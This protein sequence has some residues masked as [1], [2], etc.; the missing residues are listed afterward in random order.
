M[1]RKS[2][3]VVVLS[4]LLLVLLAGCCLSHEWEE[5]T[6]TA[7]QTCAKCG[8]TEG[9]PL[10]HTWEDAT[11]TAPKTCSVCG[12]T[13]GD[14]LPH[15]WEE[16]TCSAPK[17][18]SVCGETEGDALPH[19][20]EDATCTKAKTCSVCGKTSGA[21]LGH[22]TGDWEVESEPTEEAD[23]KYVKICSVCGKVVES[24]V[25]RM[26]PEAVTV[27]TTG[28]LVMSE[29]EY[30]R[31]FLRYLS[32]EY[33]IDSSGDLIKRSGSNDFEIASIIWGEKDESYKDTITFMGP[34]AEIKSVL[35][36]AINSIDPNA[37][38]AAALE[39]WEAARNLRTGELTGIPLHT[40]MIIAYK[41]ASGDYQ[42]MF[43]TLQYYLE[44]VGY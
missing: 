5:A 8:K 17:T 18:C 7:P 3:V 31:H 1:K 16:A 25:Y 9:E 29:E 4:L 41:G 28:G 35:D 6:C 33:R 10:P 23:G 37:D 32:D 12:E 34:W 2:I 42:A 15:E 21:P 13:K 24:K 38:A 22:E 36:P 43:C 11:C 14:T 30:H 44:N 20:W 40:G 39:Y 27:L 19:E 26:P